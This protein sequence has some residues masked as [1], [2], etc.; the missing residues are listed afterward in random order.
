MSHADVV[1]TLA[2]M[3]RAVAASPFLNECG[4]L[5]MRDAAGIEA[6]FAATDWSTITVRE[7]NSE[8]CV[9]ATIPH[10]DGL[11]ERGAD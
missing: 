5:A 3:P 10:A 11:H 1:L 6:W 8:D 9:D 4:A 7:A 2:D